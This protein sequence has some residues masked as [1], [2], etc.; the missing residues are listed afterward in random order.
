MTFYPRQ[1]IFEHQ[2]ERS[3]NLIDVLPR[4]VVLRRDIEPWAHLILHK[5]VRTPVVGVRV[6]HGPDAWGKRAR[7][8]AAHPPQRIEVDNDRFFQAVW[9]LFL[10]VVEREWDPSKFHLVLHSSGLDSR[11]ISAALR[12]LCR[13]YGPDWLGDVLF[14]ECD[15]EAATFRALMGATGWAPEQYAVYRDQLVAPDGTLAPD[16]H[17]YSLEFAHAWERLNGYT[18]FPLNCWW[19]PVQ[20]LQEQGR[21]PGD[22]DLQCW[23]GHAANTITRFWNE[24]R[25]IAH[26]FKFH[27]S[28][29]YAQ[30]GLKGAWVHPF[31]DLDYIRTVYRHSLGRA[32]YRQ[33]IL[34]RVLP[35]AAS[36]APDT[37]Q[38]R[39]ARGHRDAHPV[40]LDHALA[41]YRRSWYGREVRPDLRPDPPAFEGRPRQLAY[42]EWWCAWALAS[43]CEHLRDNGYTIDVQA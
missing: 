8:L 10:E 37:W 17:L 14:V 7:D 6:V 9:P 12:T 18:A 21:I 3:P 43:L 29:A 22:E 38:Q 41:D 42:T 36:I 2:D 40:L 1:K 15:G 27:W 24:A 11:L 30:F 31:L 23:T 25:G 33:M 5:H 39:Q 35:E 13:Y 20:W 26:L 16:Y 28:T 4:R 32:D 34:E 19:E